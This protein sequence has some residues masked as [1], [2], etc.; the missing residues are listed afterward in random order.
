MLRVKCQEE[1]KGE[2]SLVLL[3][4]GLHW[5]ESMQGQAKEGSQMLTVI[6]GSTL[7]RLLPTA[8]HRHPPRSL[9]EPHAREGGGHGLRTGPAAPHGPGGGGASPWETELT[10]Q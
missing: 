10:E 8:D 7:I 6:Q 1:K 4:S 5:T 2:D 9:T 3:N